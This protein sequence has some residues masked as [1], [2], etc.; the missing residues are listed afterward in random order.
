MSGKGGCRHQPVYYGVIN[1]NVDE[2]TIGSVDV[3]HC[4]A[5][6]GRFCEEKQLGI[7]SISDEIGMPELAAGE[8]WAVIVC[9]LQKGRDKWRLARLGESG[10]VS[11]ECLGEKAVSLEVGA[12]AVRDEHHWSFLVDDHVNTAVEIAGRGVGA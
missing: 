3:W 11:H 12:H 8:R 6:K 10:R 4:P 7:E 5:C 1:I 9:Q 2:R